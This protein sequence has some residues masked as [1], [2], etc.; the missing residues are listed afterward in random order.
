M[1][2]IKK[3]LGIITSLGALLPLLKFTIKPIG[4]DARYF[5]VGLINLGLKATILAFIIVALSLYSFYLSDN[6]QKKFSI[7]FVT[8]NMI[9]VIA[10]SLILR[11]ELKKILSQNFAI[12]L[13]NVSYSYSWGWIVL[14]LG[15]LGSFIVV[16]FEFK[17]FMFNKEEISEIK[18]ENNE[19][20]L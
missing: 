1:K 6:L 19:I 16:L 3:N 8:L 17:K 4:F 14:F 12:K 11:T 10:V 5:T 15:T 2:N 13:L 9:L 20:E 7:V 18:T